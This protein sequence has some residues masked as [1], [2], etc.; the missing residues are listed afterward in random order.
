MHDPMV[1]AF[2][3]RR[4]W[5]TRRPERVRPGAPRWEWTIYRAHPKDHPGRNPRQW[6]KPGAWSP[7]V[8]VFGWRFFFPSLITI[9][10]VEPNGEDSGRIC[11]HWRDGRPDNR[12][13]WHV[14]HWHIQVPPLQ[15]LRARLFDRCELCGRRGRP[16]ISHQ[17]DGPGVGWRKWRSRSGLYHQE[18][19][20]LVHARHRLDYRAEAL[21]T[22]MA[23]TV[24]STGRDEGRIL[25]LVTRRHGPDAMPYLVQAEMAGA[26][27]YEAHDGG[28]R[29]I[30]PAVTPDR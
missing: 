29:K 23:F 1:V 17:W 8:T 10:H 13:R 11:K 25:D 2:E 5:P 28:W 21:R 16:N 7:F 24:R 20:A 27:G 26:L 9:W 15:Q 12:W 22:L 18:C 19:S 4:P 30:T 6:W 14:H 3:I